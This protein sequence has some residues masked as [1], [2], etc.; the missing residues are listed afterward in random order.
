MFSTSVDNSVENSVRLVRGGPGESP[1]ADEPLTFSTK[2]LSQPCIAAVS[3][4]PDDASGTSFALPAR[5]AV[6]RSLLGYE[7]GKG[8]VIE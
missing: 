1:T 8:R 6:C 4:S 2:Q 3:V 5:G 7:H